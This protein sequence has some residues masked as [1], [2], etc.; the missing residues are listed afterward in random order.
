MGGIAGLLNGISRRRR[1][2]LWDRCM[3]AIAAVMGLIP[4]LAI[5]ASCSKSDAADASIA[6]KPDASQAIAD[7]GPDIRVWLVFD[8]GSTPI[9][10]AP[11]AHRQPVHLTA[12]IPRLPPTEL[13]IS[14]IQTGT[15]GP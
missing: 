2:V 9:A 3:R 13:A 6:T 10:D 14:V 8:G 5:N 15:N 12:R 1:R 7:A 4:A 11:G